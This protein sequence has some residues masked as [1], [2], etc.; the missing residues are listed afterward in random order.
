M[1]PNTIIKG[2]CLDY[3]DKIPKDAFLISDPPYNQ[4]YHYDNY[5]DNL[6]PQEYRDLL[7]QIF[8]ERKSIII[9]YPEET[10]K[11]LATLDLGNCDEVVSW[12][13]NSNTAKQ[14]RLI[15]WW[16]CKPDMKLIPQPYKNPED[17]RI[18]QRIKDGKT[19]RSYDWWNINQVKNVSKKNNCHSCPI[20]EE[21]ARRIILSTTEKGDLVVD[22]FC[23][24]GTIL[25][26]A[27]EL[28]RNF[29][30]IEISKKYTEVANQML[31]DNKD[32][33]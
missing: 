32:W 6:E 23:G 26:V 18:K 33:I 5:D 28:G 9:H 24:S 3:I 30:G 10:I 7:Y 2:N 8:S 15:T 11:I 31:D 27:K 29:I 1:K 4:K 19:C 16:N 22:P 21:I 17:R 25:K 14:H 13:Y 20:P 12:I